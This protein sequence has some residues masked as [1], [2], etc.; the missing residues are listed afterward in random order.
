[1]TTPQTI[2]AQPI[3]AQTIQA[4]A[5]WFLRHGETD[6]NAQNLS[7]GALDIPLN[8]TGIAQAE[9]AAQRLR[10]RGIQTIVASPLS[11]ARDTAEIVGA[12]LG[13]S[14]QTDPDLRE[15]AFGVQEGQPMS[16]WFHDWVA[17]HTT[18][19]GAETFA[20]LGTRGVTALNRAL[21]LEAPV[22]VVAHGALFRAIRGHMGLPVT[23][24]TANAE[25][26]FCE[27]GPIWTL[28]PA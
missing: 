1:M 20:A 3:Q 13:L 21:M 10:N 12:A 25:P 15:V 24:R 4:R 6:W 18:P 14:V 9:S 16:D 17:G 26:Y 23:I 19:S 28:T 5:F 27:P 11:R 8:A 22:L 7:Q 2:Q